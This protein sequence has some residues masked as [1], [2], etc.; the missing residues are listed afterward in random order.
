MNSNNLS[1]FDNLPQQIEYL[2]LKRNHFREL[3]SDLVDKQRL[4]FLDLSFNHLSDVGVLGQLNCLKVLLLK[5]NQV[6][7][8]AGLGNIRSL[9]ELDLDSNLIEKVEEVNCFEQHQSI[10]VL[11]LQHNPVV[12]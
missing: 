7:K 9:I 1:S 5:G 4:L 11:N 2:S 3:P 6:S 10:A 8:V 12:E